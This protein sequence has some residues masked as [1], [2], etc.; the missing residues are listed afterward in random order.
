[1][2]PFIQ[3]ITSPDPGIRNR[4]FFH[5]CRGLSGNELLTALDEL[6]SFRTSTSNLYEKVRAAIFL[7]AGYR[8]FLMDSDEFPAT[9]QIPPEGFENLLNRNFEKAVSVFSDKIKTGANSN[10]FSCIAESYHQ[11]TFQT[12]AD[13]VKKSV[14]N[15]IGNRWMFRV[16]HPTEHPLSIDRGLLEISSESG[17]Y[18]V[19]REKTPVRMDLTHSCWSD[20]FFLGM[21]YPEGARVINVS[22]NLGVYGR[23]EGTDS[24]IETYFR[25]IREP[26]LRLTSLDLKATKDISE[27]SDLFNFANDYL[28]LLKAAVIASGIIPPSFEGTHYT[29]K[30]IL[31]NLL[32]G[33]LG[34]ELVTKVNDIPK[35]S[36]LAVSTNL[37][38]SMIGLMMRASGQAS[39][40]TGN[41]EEEERRL[42][43]SRAILGE[44]LGGSGGGWQDSGGIWPG[45]KE[46]K[47][48]FATEGDIEYKISRGCLLPEHNLLEENNGLNTE[49]PEQLEDSLILMHGGMASN[50]GPV[51]EMVTEKYLLRSAE[52]W[53]ARQEANSIYD[54]IKESLS[55]N[56]IDAM[57]S[58]TSKN[59][60]GPIKT[61]I[62]WASTY[63]TEVIINRAKKEFGQDYLGFLMLGGMSGGG[64]GMFIR[65]SKNDDVKKRLLE[66]LVTTKNE[67]MSYLPFAMEPVVYNFKIN[68]DGSVS[69][70]LQG[71]DALM[72]RDY[73][74]LIIPGLVKKDTSTVPDM[75]KREFDLVTST[76]SRFEDSYLML[77]SFVGS[78]FTFS[79]DAEVMQKAENDMMTDKVKKENGFDEIQ[80]EQIRSDLIKGRIGLSRN[81]LP[82]ETV[83]EDVAHN[84]L[85]HSNDITDTNRKGAD[86]LKS[87][88][89]G[90]VCLAAGVGSRW[91]QGAG[92]IK[93][94][95]PFVEL[96]GK[97]RSFIE[98]HLAKS[99]KTTKDYSA[100][101]P[102][103]F[104]TS[105]L[106]HDPIN[107][108][109]RKNKNFSYGGNVYLSPG[110]SIGQ[111]F[112]P[113]ARD[114]EYLWFELQNEV[115]D[116]NKQKVRDALRETLINWAKSRGEAAD[117]KDNIAE[118]RIYPL[119][120]WFEIPNMIRN[121]VLAEVIKD[122]PGLEHLML[123]NVDTAG[124]NLSPE[125]LNYHAASGNVL[126]FEVI[127]RRIEDSGGGLAKIN[128]KVRILEGLAQPREEDELSLSYYN[129]MT[130]WINIDKLLDLFKLSRVDLNNLPEDKLAESVR[131][132]A[133]QLP[134]YVT[135][136]DVKYRW[137]NGQE[138][139]Y[140]VCQVE[141]LWSDMSGLPDIQCG[142]VNVPRKRGQQ[143]KDPAQLDSWVYDGSKDYVESSCLFD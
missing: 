99:S 115:L 20:I 112:I 131:N 62:P 9:G 124:V 134:S 95:N 61:I 16:G 53:H 28:G 86:L 105:H 120:H 89:A 84:E 51:L 109:L 1:M 128:G 59:F 8:F 41:L 27:L 65:K 76:S 35:G 73:Y 87:G 18:P 26:V 57:A 90:I 72:P 22:V 118:Q 68:R 139:I 7:Y 34:I 97:H 123:H 60:F 67:M 12:L 21:D 4:S 85:V 113:M 3:T 63:Y 88:K 122:N 96:N 50:V 116:E 15:N 11:M 75:R 82:A 143:L 121:G 14:R 36:R 100:Q 40:L 70:L 125:I 55:G 44:W 141:K 69:K 13:Q 135:I 111:R 132:M 17:L 110:K 25:I 24:P 2:N 48:V 138:D 33:D 6:D 130:T 47:G 64:M 66:I 119:G 23:D 91:T 5:L 126:T 79:S 30:E 74:S 102:V 32:P 106:T 114:L 83:I 39:T 129:S 93:A 54:G 142:Y 92:V 78:L 136:K 19:L 140:P 107:K 71:N 58:L 127:P 104:T 103:V 45:I 108:V 98:I 77:R 46:I 49:L 52:E 81:R 56:S 42:I 94:L 29:I 31:A 117:Y 38:A 133:R 10:L 101:I 80:H 37:L 43:A 137:G